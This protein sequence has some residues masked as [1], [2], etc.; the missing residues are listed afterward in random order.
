MKPYVIAEVAQAHE[1]S[2]NIAHAFIDAVARTRGA[3]AIKFQTHFASEES[4]ISEPWRIKFSRLEESRYEYWKRMQFSKE[5]WRG[6]VL[7]CQEVGLDFISSPFSI[8]AARLLHSIGMTTWKIASGE[9]TNFPM[10]DE[11]LRLGG[12]NFVVSTGLGDGAEITALRD[13][14]RKKGGDITLLSCV[15]E[16]PSKLLDVDMDQMVSYKSVY[17]VPYGLSDHSGSVYPSLCAA[18]KGASVLEVHVTFHRDF[19]GPDNKASLTL[20]QLEQLGGALEE[21]DLICSPAPAAADDKS[22][23]RFL[24]MKGLVAKKDL[25]AG[26]ILENKHLAYK[27]PATGISAASYQA[28]EGAVLTVA[29]NKDEPIHYEDLDLKQGEDSER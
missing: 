12:R 15:S 24:F 9:V 22:R 1:G 5:Q 25:A 11:I 13:R 18:V 21:V 14:I 4:T 26:T 23:M 7:H 19:F 16:Y 3:S 27:K 28:I 6:L 10:I 29:K 8:K 17:D 20:E 2:I